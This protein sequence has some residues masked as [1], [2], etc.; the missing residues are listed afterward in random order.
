MKGREVF[1]FLNIM[2]FV[3]YCGRDYGSLN[4]IRH[5]EK[6]YV[7]GSMLNFYFDY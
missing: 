4:T 7:R 6:K 1:M 5:Y 3:D 2:I